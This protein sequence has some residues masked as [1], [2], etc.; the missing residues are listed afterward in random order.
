MHSE[1]ISAINIYVHSD[2]ITMY[3]PIL[4]YLLNCR[5]VSSDLEERLLVQFQLLS[6]TGS[7]IFAKELE[8]LCMRKNIKWTR[9]LPV[10]SSDNFRSKR[11]IGIFR[12]DAA[13]IMYH[14]SRKKLFLSKV[15]SQQFLENYFQFICKW[16]SP[17]MTSANFKLR[18]SI[19][20]NMRDKREI[21][22]SFMRS[23]GNRVCWC[24]PSYLR[25]LAHSIY[26]IILRYIS[27]YY[28]DFVS[29]HLHC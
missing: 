11:R 5:L 20:D 22:Y 1:P 13:V 25:K 9:Y 19:N 21:Y 28:S 24:G 10:Y 23:I 15:N 18:N 12:K 3:S 26:P 4:K 2:L 27:K 8:Q 6:H 7:L 14:V 16:F 29:P 17:W